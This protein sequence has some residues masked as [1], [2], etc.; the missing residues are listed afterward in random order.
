MKTDNTELHGIA[1]LCSSLGIGRTTVYRLLR[2]EIPAFKI[3]NK[4]KYYQ[5]DLE[6][7]I[8][9]RRN[10][11]NGQLKTPQPAKGPKQKP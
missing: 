9:R 5:D 4:W 10:K 6:K 2:N 8:C 7:Y 11:K 3:G 1:D